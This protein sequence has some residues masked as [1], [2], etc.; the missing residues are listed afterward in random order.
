[1]RLAHNL[2]LAGSIHYCHLASTPTLHLDTQKGPTLPTITFQ[3]VLRE[4]K[5]IL[6]SDYYTIPR[7]Q[8]PYSWGQEHLEEFWTD[9]VDK[10][11]DGYFIGPMVAYKKRRDTFPIVDGQQRITTLTLMLCG[12]RDMFDKVG[13]DDLANGVTKYIERT[14]DDNISHFVL[15]SDPAGTFLASQVQM[16]EPRTI[17]SPTNEDQTNIKRA[18]VDITRRL[19]TNCPT[20]L[21]ERIEDDH[22]YLIELKRVRDRVLSLQVIW[23]ILDNLDDA[24]MI[25][26]TLNSRGRDLDVVDLLKNHLLSQAKAENGD[27]D[28]PAEQWNLMRANLAERG[29]GINPNTF[30]LHWWLSR[31]AY[32]SERRLFRKMK[33]DGFGSLT[34]EEVVKELVDDSVLYARIAN[35]SDWNC[36][37]EE[38]GIRESLSALEIFTVRQPR[39]LLL[40]LLRAHASGV[41]RLRKLR[42][43]MTAI[44][45]F[46]FITTAVVGV[47]STGGQSQMYASYARQISKAP[48]TQEAALIIDELVLRLQKAISAR[49]T[50]EAEFAQ[51]LQYTEKA[52]RSKRL[53]QYALRKMH[54][55]SNLHNA[56]DHTKCNIEHVA[57]QR[58]G[59]PWVGMMG[60]LLWL[61][62]T[63]NSQLADLE[64]AEK[65]AVLTSYSDLYKV[66]NIID[67][68][69]WGEPEVVARTSI[70]AT[71]AYDQVWKF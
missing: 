65:K 25:F 62:E 57:P 20:D 64:F 2:A 12:L 45:H 8:R 61:D 50:F 16:R 10:N 53:V 29:N 44:E 49:A 56:L 41:I 4:I 37:R 43:A 22:E 31:N 71:I 1:M 63:V 59:Q 69:A 6:K 42:Q 21:E 3:P 14:D 34:V 38:R 27:L 9:V 19:A 30:I 32:V 5:D 55:A 23:I 67:Q 26:E 70:L 24:Y 68:D 48:G 52:P 13:R 33:E 15:K 66:D 58:S 7:F 39:P 60:N 36:S 28:L 11:D 46:H 17:S 40:A 18:F 35:P 47:S 51:S 54:D